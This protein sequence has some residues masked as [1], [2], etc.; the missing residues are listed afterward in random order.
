MAK[1]IRMEISSKKN[2]YGKAKKQAMQNSCTK[3]KGSQ[4]GEMLR[5]SKVKLN[6]V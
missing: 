2:P 1:K 4:K 6:A 3:L 5:Y